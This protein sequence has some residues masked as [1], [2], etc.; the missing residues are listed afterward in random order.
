MASGA[1]VRG[2]D[3][4]NLDEA[5]G[6]LAGFEPAHSSLPLTRGLMRVLRPV[7]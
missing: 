4:V 7:V 2:N 5:L 6:V 3:S 1:E